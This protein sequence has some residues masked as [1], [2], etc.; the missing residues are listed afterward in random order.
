MNYNDMNNEL[1]HNLAVAYNKGDFFKWVD[2]DFGY[3]S[4]ENNFAEENSTLGI[5][6]LFNEFCTDEYTLSEILEKICDSGSFDALMNSCKQYLNW[7]DLRDSCEKVSQVLTKDVI[8]NVE[9]IIDFVFAEKDKLFN[10]PAFL[11]SVLACHFNKVVNDPERWAKLKDDYYEERAM[12]Y[13]C[14]R[15]YGM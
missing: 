6:K 13:A 12:D 5:D 8:E 10:E 15:W 1:I 9:D 4:I 3:L 7:E 2:V 14:D 11:V